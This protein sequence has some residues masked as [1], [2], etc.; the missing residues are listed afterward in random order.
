MD[1]A[2]VST[3]VAQSQAPQ[4]AVLI[5]TVWTGTDTNIRSSMIAD[6]VGTPRSATTTFFRSFLVQETGDQVWMFR[7]ELNAITLQRL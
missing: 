7:L 4:Q 6:V 3:R 1:E 2:A 5:A